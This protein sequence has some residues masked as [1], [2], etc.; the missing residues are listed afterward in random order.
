MAKKSA[1]T[2]DIAA[3]INDVREE[4][5]LGEVLRGAPI[6]TK[7]VRVFTDSVTGERLG[8]QEVV[9][10]P[11]DFGVPRKELRT[12]GIVKDI[13]DLSKTKEDEKKNA[14]QIATLKQEARGLAEKLDET[15]LV[16]E[17]QS[18]PPVIKKD[19]RRA[20]KVHLGIRGK[21]SE[22]QEQE[23]IEEL[24]AQILSRCAVS[25]YSVA[26]DKTNK[27]LSVERAREL[28]NLLLETEYLRIDNAINELIY[29]SV[30][31]QK[32]VEDPDF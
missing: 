30:I 10:V 23:F 3:L 2:D 4:F 15:A 28:R 14:K 13:A 26:Q 20:A 1:P 6:R 8:G 12:W 31:A 7:K 25:V 5:D 29:Q 22:A 16:I 9:L 18:I 21:V 17:L 27:G 11:G 32:V 24:D 19:A